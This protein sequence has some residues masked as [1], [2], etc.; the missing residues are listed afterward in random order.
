MAYPN[1]LAIINAWPSLSEFAADIDASYNTAKHIRRRERIPPEYW[2][3]VV[4]H[5]GRRAIAGINA[6]LLA[7]L[8]PISR[9]AR[10]AA[11]A[12]M[13]EATQ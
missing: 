5:A 10:A 4:A 3:L 2:P 7:R 1:H 6:D 13:A 12:T 9:P 8:Y 11:P